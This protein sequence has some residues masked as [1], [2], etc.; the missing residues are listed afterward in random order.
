MSFLETAIHYAGAHA[1]NQ[2]APPRRC[3]RQLLRG[4]NFMTVN[5]W[6]S[7]HGSEAQREARSGRSRCSSVLREIARG[8]AV[9]P[10]ASD[11]KKSKFF[12][13]HRTDRVHQAR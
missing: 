8:V 1:P 5:R 2:P 10:P 11:L 3:S 4:I 13:G 12:V 7:H 6:P 9:P